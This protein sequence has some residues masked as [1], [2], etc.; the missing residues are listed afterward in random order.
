MPKTEANSF[1]KQ[2]PF[3]LSMSIN[4]HRCLANHCQS[5]AHLGSCTCCPTLDQPVRINTFNTDVSYMQIEVKYQ[6]AERKSGI[7]TLHLNEK[8]PTHTPASPSRLHNR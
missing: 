7:T 8:P 3:E 4:F 6:M 1:H 2:H 5:V